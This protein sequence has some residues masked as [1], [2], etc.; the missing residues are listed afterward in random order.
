MKSK[1]LFRGKVQE[2]PALS[3]NPAFSRTRLGYS[4]NPRSERKVHR[5]SG[6][7]EARIMPSLLGRKIGRVNASK[8][9]EV[10]SEPAPIKQEAPLSIGTQKQAPPSEVKQEEPKK[11]GPPHYCPGVVYRI[12]K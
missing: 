9:R 6:T 4:V 1:E 5:K 10:P 3:E 12:E 11:E 2:I 7:K 8:P